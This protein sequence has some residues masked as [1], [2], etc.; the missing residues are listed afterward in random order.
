VPIG[1]AQAQSAIQAAEAK[2]VIG[3]SSVPIGTTQ[4]ASLCPTCGKPM[5]G[6]ECQTC[7]QTTFIKPEPRAEVVA[8]APAP[9]PPALRDFV[10]MVDN[11]RNKLEVVLYP[12]EL[13]E[14]Q[15]ANEVAV[16]AVLR[17]LQVKNTLEAKIRQAIGTELPPD[18]RN[19][20]VRKLL[21]V[22]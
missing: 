14:G 19:R 15:E 13:P 20:M 16:L 5:T 11:L 22:L 9:E 7:G 6:T 3:G 17:R 21:S 1:T 10:D 18:M 2:A 12:A 8:A 4:A